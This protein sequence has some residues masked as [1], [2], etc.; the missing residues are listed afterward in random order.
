MY[1]YKNLMET[2]VEDKYGELKDSLSCCTCE[3]CRND[4]IAYALNQLPTKYVVSVQ[5]SLYTK[6]NM[7][8]AQY[9][10]DVVSAIVRGSEL[11]SAHPRHAMRE[12]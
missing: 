11:V 4:I 6:L 9:S 2:L 10:T 3:E 8:G 7:L 5:G 12:N 1:K